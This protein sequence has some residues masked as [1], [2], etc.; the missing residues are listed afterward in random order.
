MKRSMKWYT[1]YYM[2]SVRGKQWQKKSVQDGTEVSPHTYDSIGMLFRRM[3][4]LLY[5]L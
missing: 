1:L 5:A 3:P 2:L 4:F